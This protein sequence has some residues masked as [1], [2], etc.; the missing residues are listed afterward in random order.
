MPDANMSNDWTVDTDWETVAWVSHDRGD[1]CR[2]RA[3]CA[4]LRQQE[5]LLARAITSM[6]PIATLAA[7]PCTCDDVYFGRAGNYPLRNALDRARNSCEA[8]VV[9]CRRSG[10]GYFQCVGSICTGSVYVFFIDEFIQLVNQ[11]C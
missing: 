5:G 3:G 11:G 1:Y 10:L 6:S 8:S 2:T 7:I 9:G 4:G